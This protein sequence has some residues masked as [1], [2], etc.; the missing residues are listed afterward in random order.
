MESLDTGRLMG[1]FLQLVSFRILSPS[2]LLVHSINN[3]GNFAVHFLDSVKL[4]SVAMQKKSFLTLAAAPFNFYP[5]VS[6]FCCDG[7]EQLIVD[8]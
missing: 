3:L 5:L 2:I 7:T 8:L 4:L 1:P 6:Y